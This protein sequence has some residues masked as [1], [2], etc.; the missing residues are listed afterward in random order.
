M[1]RMQIEVKLL[2]IYVIT[3][4]M[5]FGRTFFAIT[6]H[7]MIMYNNQLT[8][9]KT[10]LL[11]VMIL[12]FLFLSELEIKGASRRTRWN[13]SDKSDLSEMI[14]EADATYEGFF[15]LR[16]SRD[17]CSEI[18]PWVQRK[19]LWWCQTS[20]RLAFDRFQFIIRRPPM[21]EA[22]EELEERFQVTDIWCKLKWKCQSV[23]R[24]RKL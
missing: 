16:Q 17:A 14:S 20:S 10:S 19:S 21:V 23:R 3:V 12:A 4:M 5:S 15:V 9:R 6:S 8:R 2:K 24:K 18:R 7:V 13:E 1:I 11:I 22:E